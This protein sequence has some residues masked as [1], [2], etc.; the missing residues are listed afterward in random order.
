MAVGIDLLSCAFVVLELSWVLDALHQGAHDVRSTPLDSHCKLT[1]SQ[2]SNLKLSNSQFFL[3]D[4][5]RHDG[6]PAH[7]LESGVNLAFLQISS[8]KAPI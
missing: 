7:R 6:C 3:P 4:V 1:I 8:V 5:S 2:I